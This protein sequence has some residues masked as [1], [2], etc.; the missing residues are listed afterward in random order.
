MRPQLQQG[1]GERQAGPEVDQRQDGLAEAGDGG[2]ELG[3]GPR[4]NTVALDEGAKA[5]CG[6]SEG[7]DVLYH[8]NLR[9]DPMVLRS[10]KLK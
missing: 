9:T 3:E 7:K 10:M 6:R 2:G 8:K 4:G 5:F 1:G